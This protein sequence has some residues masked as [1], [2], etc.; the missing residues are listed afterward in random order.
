MIR[1][2]A[3]QSFCELT[4]C[5]AIL[6]SM[7]CLL[8]LSCRVWFLHLSLDEAGVVSNMSGGLSGHHSASS[9]HI[10]G[11]PHFHLQFR[12][13]IMLA[14]A[15]IDPSWYTHMGQTQTASS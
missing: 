15:L 10:R 7:W 8:V 14:V 3:L 12:I 1:H 6:G 5:R 13:L 2:M 4:R 11:S 9:S